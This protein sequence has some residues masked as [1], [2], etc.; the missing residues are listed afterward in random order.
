LVASDAAPG[1]DSGQSKEEILRSAKEGLRVYRAL[2]ARAV[3]VFGDEIMAAH[4]LSTPNPDFNGEQ[5]LEAARRAGMSDETLEQ[6][7]E[8][9][10][11]RI[12]E[13]IYW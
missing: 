1:Q 6:I 12:E 4:W 3:D 13:G 2:V 10:F 7:L 9:V 8:P 11:V 5:P